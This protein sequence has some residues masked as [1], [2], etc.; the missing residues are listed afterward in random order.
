MKTLI[1]TLLLALACGLLGVAAC[2]KPAPETSPAAPAPEAH[3]LGVQANL[4]YDVAALAVAQGV[5]DYLAAATLIDGG[6]ETPAM[7]VGPGPS[8]IPISGCKFAPSAALTASNTQYAS[9][10][11]S[12]R[13][14]LADAS[15]TQATIAWTT[16]AIT[17]ADAGVDAA[18]G[19]WSI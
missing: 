2:E 14:P 13:T 15:T 1:S 16:T 17:A 18:T 8:S 6:N 3:K 11:V 4:S 10:T 7:V 5:V 12:K 19:S 9:L